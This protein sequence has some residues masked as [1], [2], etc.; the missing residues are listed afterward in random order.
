MELLEN[1]NKILEDAEEYT[2]HNGK[3]CYSTFGDLDY[4]L[5]LCSKFNLEPKPITSGLSYE[6]ENESVCLDYCEHDI[7]LHI[8]KIFVKA[9]ISG[10]HE[11]SK[12]QAKKWAT[13]M[14]NGSSCKREKVIQIINKRIIG[15]TLESL[16][17]L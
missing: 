13:H 3:I 15:A 14:L 5:L 10:W 7:I 1:I 2:A 16:G 17:V 12:E 8:K 11:V 9:L 4:Y 6:A